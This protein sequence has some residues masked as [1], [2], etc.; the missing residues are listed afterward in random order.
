[1]A[2]NYDYDVLVLGSGPGGYV[3]AIRASQL[4][5]KCA[6]V[7]R[8]NMGGICLNWGC[9]PKKSL[10]HNA[11][12]LETVRDEAEDFGIT[13]D[14]LQVDFGSAIKRSLGIVQRQTKGV[15]FLMKKNK[16]D[17][18]EGHGSFVD[19][20]V[21][22][23]TPSEINPEAPEKTVSAANII[24]ATGGRARGLPNVEFDGERILH[25]RHA[26]RPESQPKS[27]VIIGAGAI[28]MELGHFYHTYGTET[29]IVEMM[30]NV[31]PNEEPEVSAEVEKAFKARGVQI[32][33]GS[34]ADA[35]KV[36]KKS[37]TLTIKSLADESTQNINVEKVLLAINIIPNTE[38]IGAEV[39][40][41]ALDERG[42][43]G[44]DEVMRTNISHIYAIGDCTGKLALAH[45]ASAMA[46][47]AAETIGGVETIAIPDEKYTFMPRCTYCKPEVASMGMTEAQAKAA[48]YELNIGKF[49]FLPNGKSQAI[50]AKAG[51]VKLIADAKYGEI[52]G[53]HIVGPQAT[54]LLPELSLAQFMEITPAEIARTVHAH[55]TLS[56]IIMEAAHGVE[57]HPIHM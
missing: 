56:E 37:V 12:V 44:V 26:I 15:S 46:I 45:V 49:P 55:P 53:A 51:F 3:A 32:L 10:L 48:G 52:L 18:L 16:I 6:I 7:E 42:F 22:K 41:V 19:D 24:I 8:E 23:V 11:E 17:V 4:G 1:M 28:G 31:L 33:T 13:F 39:A 40:G 38:T 36:N 14:N 43:V 35:I 47:T 34:I 2:D 30:E 50:N 21:I 57:G 27:M 29:T 54:E 25:Y 9:I 5:L 20:H